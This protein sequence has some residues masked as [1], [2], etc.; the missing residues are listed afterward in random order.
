MAIRKRPVAHRQTPDTPASPER[1][2]KILARAGLGSRRQLESAIQAGAILVN[3]QPAELGSS[4]AEDDRVEYSNRR[5]RVITSTQPQQTLLYNKPVGEITTHDDPQGRRT[6]F[7]RLPKPDNGRWVTIG[8]LDINTSGLLI[9][10]TDGELA[11][12]MMHPSS[13]IDREYACRVHGE[14]SAQQLQALRDGVELEDGPARFSDIAIAGS[15]DSNHWYQVTIMEGRN[16]EVRRL[17]A[18]QGVEVSRLQRVRYGAAFLPKGLL[19]GQWHWLSDKDHKVLRED[20]KLPPHTHVLTLQ[21]E[22]PGRQPRSRPGHKPSNQRKSQRGSDNPWQAANRS[23]T[24][25]KKTRS[26]S[27][28][29]RSEQA[30]GS[31][32]KKRS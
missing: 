2:Q 17:W 18:T 4:L 10:T 15:G 20:V 9:L 8:R 26:A 31:P 32:R 21:P 12:A 25:R 1:I 29:G 28:A 11:H 3:G 27:G 16:R 14:V 23:S 22:Q 24:G 5:Y 6:V 30:K 19:R 7:A 13:K